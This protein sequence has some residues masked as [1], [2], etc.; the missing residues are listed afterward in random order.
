MNWLWSPAI[1]GLNWISTIFFLLLPLLSVVALFFLRRKYLWATP[2][3]SAV[4][5]IAMGVLTMPSILTDNEHRGMFFGL[6]VPI[7]LI[8][9]IV[10]TA[11][12]YLIAFLL[13]QARQNR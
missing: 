3:L 4:L 9:A 1:F 8:V 13:K 12:A 7:H 2:L 10:F 6:T 5:A 11:A